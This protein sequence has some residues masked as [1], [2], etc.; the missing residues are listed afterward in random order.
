MKKFRQ[1]LGWA[2]VIMST[3]FACFWA[4]WGIIENFHEGWFYLSLWNNLSMMIIQYLS[5][6]IIFVILALIG[7]KWPKISWLFYIG[8]AIFLWYFFGLAGKFSA[9]APLTQNFAI[10]FK[11]LTTNIVALFSVFIVILGFFYT[12]GNPRPLKLAYSLV[13][14]LPL[15]TLLI[16]G[17]GPAIRVSQRVDDGNRGM[18]IVQGSQGKS[19]AWAPEGLGWPIKG[20]SLKEAL[21]RCQYLNKEGTALAKE[22]QNIWR[23][24]TIRETVCSLTRNGKN[25]GG[26]WNAKTGK[27]SYKITPD[28][29]TPLWNPH[30]QIIYWWTSSE[31]DKEHAYRISYN[32]YVLVVSK[33]VCMDYWG[34][35]AVKNLD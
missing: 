21:K 35:R 24:P 20:V 9:H 4:F 16:C 19:L 11:L 32:G 7:L 29:E 13:L 6:M 34:F 5:S 10:F 27:P 8:V 14:V 30:S 33:K 12:F 18:R 2:A 15:A 17:I 1:I 31:K 22:P 25:A 26:S 23:L 3:F 28:K